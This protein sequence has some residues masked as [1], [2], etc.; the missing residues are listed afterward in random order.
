MI[1]LSIPFNKLP[2]KKAQYEE[3]NA[4]KTYVDSSESTQKLAQ[5]NE[6]RQFYASFTGYLGS[7]SIFSSPKSFLV[8]LVVYNIL[9]NRPGLSTFFDKIMMS[10]ELLFEF[11]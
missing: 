11:Y 10:M 3:E 4:E 7:T 6:F 2:W 8:K 1:L 5:T 9:A